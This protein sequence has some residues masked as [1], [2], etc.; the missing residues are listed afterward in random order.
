M[1][2]WL[3]HQ[4]ISTQFRCDDLNVTPNV[5][6][7][8]YLAKKDKIDFIYNTTALEG[9]PMT[10]PEVQ[11]LLEGITVGG[12][13]V[14]DE[15]QVLNQNKAVDLLLQM[16]KDKTFHTDQTTVCALH[17]KVAYEE[18]LTWGVFRD[19]PVNIG[20]TDYKPPQAEDL[21]PIFET[22]IQEILQIESPIIRALC[23]LLFGSIN[24]FFWDGNKRTS[25]LMMNGLLISHGYPILNI[26]AK[27][28]LKFNQQMVA[29]YDSQDVLVALGYLLAYYIKQNKCYMVR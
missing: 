3:D 16:V 7:F 5:E 2:N 19:G 26:K 20:G 25:R 12:H 23:Y 9:N 10:F 29:F 14:S 24:Q 13:K 22:G 4:V 15:Q 8:Y 1:N 6:L 28:R 18:T 21:L 11:T 17:A 27:D